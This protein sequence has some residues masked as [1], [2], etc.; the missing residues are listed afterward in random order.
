M[1][2]KSYDAYCKDLA[3]MYFEP[4]VVRPQAQNENEAELH[5]KWQKQAKE[6]FHLLNNQKTK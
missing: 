5:Q 6:F 1:I 4:I 3:R 2:Y